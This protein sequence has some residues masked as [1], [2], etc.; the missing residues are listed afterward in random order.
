[1]PSI[2]DTTEALSAVGVVGVWSTAGEVNALENPV[3]GRGSRGAAGST[4]RGGFG[5]GVNA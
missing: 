5:G 4:E 1:V 3:T 2:S